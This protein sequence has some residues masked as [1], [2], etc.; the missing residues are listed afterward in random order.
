M[1][2]VKND[3][4]QRWSGKLNIMEV[5][6]LTPCLNAQEEEE[7]LAGAEEAVFVADNVN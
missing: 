3:S 4:Q 6:A 2:T 7:K 5:W 1:L